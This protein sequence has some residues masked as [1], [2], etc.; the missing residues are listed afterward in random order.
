MKRH[1][2]Y[3]PASLLLLCLIGCG[4]GKPGPTLFPVSGTVKLGGKPMGGV[5]VSLVATDQSKALALSGATKD[6]GTFEIL[7]GQGKR[8]APEGN[9][10]VLLLKAAGGAGAAGA[11]GD[12]KDAYS[13][14][15]KDPRASQAGVEIPKEY[16][17]AETTTKTFD[18]KKTGA[19][20]LNI[21]L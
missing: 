3:F 4:G 20:T 9:Y 16:Q 7:T 15:K 10:K 17:S 6:D 1:I 5:T 11:A 12:M 2:S 18:V 13:K 19:N 21:E 8:G 14:A